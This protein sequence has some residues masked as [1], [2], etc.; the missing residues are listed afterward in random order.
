VTYFVNLRT[1]NVGGA[2]IDPYVMQGDGT[3]N[4]PALRMIDW[5]SV[6]NWVAG[7]NLVFATHGFNVSLPHGACSLGQLEPHLDLGSSDV[8]FGVLWPGDFWLPVINYPFEGGVAM[9]CGRRLAAACDRYLSQAQSL[10][11]ISHSLGARLILEAVKNLARPAKSVCLTAAAINRDCLATEYWTA[12]QNAAV[13]SILASREDWVLKVA[14]QIGDPIADALQ[15][16]HA[17]FQPA[18]GSKGPPVPASPPIALPWQIPD[19]ANYGHGDYLPPGD[20]VQNAEQALAAKWS[21]AAAFM[22]RAFA[23]QAQIWP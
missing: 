17:P 6:A 4:P 3:A 22:A 23:G 16:D 15:D 5:P 20:K 9:D 10:S 7:K 21:N 12:A 13:I 2:V 8:Y 14:F 19:T 11:F 18:L 1:H